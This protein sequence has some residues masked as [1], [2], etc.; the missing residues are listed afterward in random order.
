MD[1][2]SQITSIRARRGSKR[3]DIQ[4]DG[5]EWRTVPRAVLDALGLACGDLIDPDQITARI[6]ELEPSAARE[7]AVRLLAYRDRSSVEMRSR[8]AE[9][10]YTLQ[11][12]DETLAWLLDTGLLDDDRFAEQLARSLIVGRRYGRTRSLQRLRSAGVPDEIAQS[13]LDAYAPQENELDRALSLGRSLMRPGETAERLASRLVRRGFTP[14][15][16]LAAAR[17]L[18]SHA[19][20]SDPAKGDGP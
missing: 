20:G 13:A 7:R 1:T 17:T 8:L 5:A 9:D 14:G 3:R 19:A 12:I 10:G 16:A 15:D 11:V 18:T 4:L 2:R 6:Q